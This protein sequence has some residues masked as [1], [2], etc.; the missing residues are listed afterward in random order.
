[1]FTPPPGIVGFLILLAGCIIAVPVTL[2]APQIEAQLRDAPNDAN[3]A[4]QPSQGRTG[5][6]I[7][8]TDLH[9]DKH[10]MEGADSSTSCHRPGP[11]A[12]AGKF[13]ALNTNCDSPPALID[14]VFDFIKTLPPNDFVLF[15]GDAVRHNRDKKVL[16]RQPA[17]VFEV[18]KYIVDKFQTTLPQ[19]TPVYP[20]LGNNDVLHN[21]DVGGNDTVYDQIKQIW[22]PWRLNLLDSFLEGGYYATDVIPNQLRLL[23]TN[24][25]LFIMENKLV[26]EDCDDTNAP[27][28]KHIAWLQAQLD[29]ARV[30][31]VKVY[32]SVHVPPN[33]KRDRIFYKPVCYNAYYKLLG[34]YGDVILG[35]FS[36]H[37]NND[38]LTAVVEG[39]G[40]DQCNKTVY[41]EAKAR[42]KAAKAAEKEKEQEQGDNSTGNDK[43]TRGL[44]R[45]YRRK[46]Q[47]ISTSDLHP[48]YGHVALLGDAIQLPDAAPRVKTTLFGA[49]AIIPLNNPAIRV[50]DYEISGQNGVPVGTI[51]N[52]HQYYADL[53]Q[54]NKNGQLSFQLE[55][56]ANEVYGVDR[57]DAS[58]TAQAFANVA[59]H[60]DKYVQYT[61][62][63]NPLPPPPDDG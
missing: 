19:G 39:P 48:P 35:Q 22:A 42:K 17:E 54:G 55:Y 4:N 13:G 43:Q 37:F 45:L 58:G 40:V 6:F 61:R 47:I 44:H 57:F 2:T 9:M 7:Q 62:V 18:Q 25:M 49:P 24:T 33:S 38:I 29:D 20:V 41:A 3:Q 32:L 56:H 46:K 27:G 34:D 36:G 21:N 63:R 52:F 26:V 1:M 53:T 50:Y 23:A 12:D 16:P 59:A 60:P 15:S 51:L 14:A 31:K 28:A 11:N 5:R 8:I 10:Y 30:N